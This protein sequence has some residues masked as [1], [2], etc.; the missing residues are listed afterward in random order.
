MAEDLIGR[1]VLAVFED[2]LECLSRV[3]YCMSIIMFVMC[4]EL[5]NAADSEI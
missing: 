1:S 5:L 3:T 4:S 2:L